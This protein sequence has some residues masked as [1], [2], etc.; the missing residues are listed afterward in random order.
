MAKFGRFLGYA[1][2]SA[3]EVQSQLYTAFD[4]KCIPNKFFNEAY[5]KA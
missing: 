2:R 3:S 5:E 4:Q 1:K